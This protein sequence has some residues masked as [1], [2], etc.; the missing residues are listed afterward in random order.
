[1]KVNIKY[2]IKEP[3]TLC[4]IRS[5]LNIYILIYIHVANAISICNGKM[6]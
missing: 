1:M 6:V 3:I 4:T 2:I 5:D